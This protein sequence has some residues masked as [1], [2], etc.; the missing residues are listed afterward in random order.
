[1]FVS[2]ENEIASF[3]RTNNANNDKPLKVKVAGDG[4]KVHRMSFPE[5][6][7]CQ[8]IDKLKTLA[9]FTCQES[10]EIL[11]VCCGPIITKLNELISIL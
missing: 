9:I 3:I 1:M 5:T 7:K 2:I 6:E 10:Y 8:S 11:S 4:T